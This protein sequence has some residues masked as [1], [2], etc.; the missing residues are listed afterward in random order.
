[1]ELALP[2]SYT[3]PQ[4][5]TVG[6]LLQVTQGSEGNDYDDCSSGKWENDSDD[7]SDK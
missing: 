7:S 1:M 3:A 4:V 5:V 2:I 6:T